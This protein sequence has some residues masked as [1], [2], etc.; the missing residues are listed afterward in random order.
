MSGSYDEALLRQLLMRH[1]TRKKA[2]VNDLVEV[3]RAVAWDPYEAVRQ[4]RPDLTVTD[5]D[6]EFRK[7]FAPGIATALRAEG[8]TV[9]G[10]A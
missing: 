3:F 5:V 9:T 6:R 8:W 2:S 4:Q 1:C 10:C 7:Q